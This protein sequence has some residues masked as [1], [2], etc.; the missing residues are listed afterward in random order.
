MRNSLISISLFIILIVGILYLNN[1]FIKICSKAEISINEIEELISNK[2]YD[3]AY[4]KSE[5]L[6]S[7]IDGNDGIPTI[8]L[9]H[10]C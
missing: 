4:E 9:N 2:E 5:E 3:L 8:Y 7:Y 6:L 10:D 1:G